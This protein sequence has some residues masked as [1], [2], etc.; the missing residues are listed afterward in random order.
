VGVRE[1]VRSS[2]TPPP[3][4]FTSCDRDVTSGSET[5]WLT[6]RVVFVRVS[7]L[8][9]DCLTIKDYLDTFDLSLPR[10][11]CSYYESSW[12]NIGIRKEKQNVD[13]NV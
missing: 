2:L 12:G 3:C 1:R 7:I 10:I 4:L 9:G 13:L 6:T 8:G 5:G 11:L